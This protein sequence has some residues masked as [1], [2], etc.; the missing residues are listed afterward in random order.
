MIL[1]ADSGSTKTTWAVTDTGNK[2]VTEGLNPHFTSDKQYLTVCDTVRSLGT[3]DEIYFYG[4]GCGDDTQRMRVKQLLQNGFHTENVNVE[5]DMLGACRSVSQDEASLVGILG[6]GSNA[7]YYDGNQIACKA[8]SLGYLL[9]DEG[10]ANHLG[11]ELLSEYLKGKM[12]DELRNLFHEAYPYSY[13]EWM[14]HIY[15]QP[16]ANRFLAS[17]ARFAVEHVD[18]EECQNDIWYVIDLWHSEQLGYLITHTHCTR[19]NVVGGFG[20]AIEGRLRTTLTD[21]GIEIGTVVADPMEGLLKY[22]NRHN[23]Q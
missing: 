5:T 15:H 8:P 16:N 22:H 13:A 19:L 9:G 23:K 3:P 18:S 10:S 6:T 21:Y 20:K 17:L 12:S 11:R 2:I 14:D 4:A 1:V 7:C